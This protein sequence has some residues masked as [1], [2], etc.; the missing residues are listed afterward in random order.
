MNDHA[1]PDI[2]RSDPIL[3][4]VPFPGDLNG[5]GHIFGGW[6]LSQM[7]I[8][9][10]IIVKRFTRH[11]C[12]TVAIESMSFIAPIH[13][14]DI[15]SVYGDVMKIGRTSLSVRMEVI[16]TRRDGDV[17]VKV[18]EG[19]FTYV[20]LDDDLRPLAVERD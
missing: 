2:D 4:A 17:D 20:A 7:D 12:A 16:A 18:T 3:R 13:V 15:V 10:G 6:V 1:L 5:N 19:I 8:A 14:G 11:V 9:G